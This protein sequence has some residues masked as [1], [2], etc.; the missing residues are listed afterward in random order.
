MFGADHFRIESPLCFVEY[1]D[2]LWRNE[3]RLGGIRFD[4]VFH[5]S[6]ESPA[7]TSGAAQFVLEN[8]DQRPI[9]CEKDGRGCGLAIGPRH[10]QIVQ[11]MRMNDAQVYERFAGSWNTG[12]KNGESR[13]NTVSAP[14]ALSPPSQDLR[15]LCHAQRN[16]RKR[17]LAIENA[18]A[19][20]CASG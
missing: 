15:S 12:E 10:G 16:S 13:F 2:M 5:A 17:C 18:G 1:Q 8:I 19:D 9:A 20:N 3:S 14:E 4:V 11:K 7:T 6:D